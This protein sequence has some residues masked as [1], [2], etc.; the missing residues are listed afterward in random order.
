MSSQEKIVNMEKNERKTEGETQR[1][2]KMREEV[3]DIVQKINTG[4][5]RGDGDIEPKMIKW[6]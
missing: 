4:R 6:L 3:K 1:A 5:E 2:Q